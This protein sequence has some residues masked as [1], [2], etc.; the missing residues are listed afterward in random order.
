MIYRAVGDRIAVDFADLELPM[1]QIEA[2]TRLSSL[3]FI[4]LRP[5][6]IEL[7]RGRIGVSTYRR[8]ARPREAPEVVDCSSFIK[9]LFGQLG[10]WLPRRTIQQCEAGEK[11][12]GDVMAGEVVYRT[13]HRNWYRRENRQGIGH[14]GLYIGDQRI[15]H[16]A[17]TERGVVE[18]PIDEFLGTTP[19]AFRG[20]RRFISLA[21]VTLEVPAAYEVE[22]SD[23]IRWIL[24]QH[25][26]RK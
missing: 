17:N 4:R 2:I 25:L 22:T 14:V 19:G 6:L 21:A 26:A 12:L 5:D 3:G 16:A 9:W 11:M 20:A 23:D 8:G 18:E 15:V 1:P 7:A 13:G 24:L 10:V